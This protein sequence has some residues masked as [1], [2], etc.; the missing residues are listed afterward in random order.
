MK[1]KY[2]SK[3]LYINLAYEIKMIFNNTVLIGLG[4]VFGIYFLYKFLFRTSKFDE[5]YNA[6]Y[7][8][9]ITSEEYKVKG[10]YDK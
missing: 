5:E 4:I 7:N 9:V 1:I 6:M 2:F 10:Q 3:H 8:K